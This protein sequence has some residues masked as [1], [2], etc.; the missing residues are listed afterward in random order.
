[1]SKTEL[2]VCDWNVEEFQAKIQTWWF[3]GMA[4]SEEMGETSKR[5]IQRESKKQGAE[6]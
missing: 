1:M 3:F 5:K 4:E 6:N 2:D